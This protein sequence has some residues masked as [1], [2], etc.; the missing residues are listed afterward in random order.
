MILLEIMIALALITLCV[1]PLLAPR[2]AMLNEQRKLIHT[3]ELDH[4][5]SLLYVDVLERL[6]KNEI[7]WKDLMEQTSFP[8]DEGMLKR[9]SPTATIP[10]GLIGTYRFDTI[11]CKT[12][13]E[14]GLTLPLLHLT[15]VFQKEDTG[16]AAVVKKF[17]FQYI[18]SALR[19]GPIDS[20]N[21]A[22]TSQEL[23]NTDDL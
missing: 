8:V 15:F 2:A 13:I 14:K 7:P 1:L 3:M 18:L 11:R 4:L 20:Q 12:N 23:E 6:H 21:S 5:V 10:H 19:I 17:V 22:E 16:D 9:I